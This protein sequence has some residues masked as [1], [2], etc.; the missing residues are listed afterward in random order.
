MAK[1]INSPEKPIAN[2]Y[3][4]KKYYKIVSIS[5]KNN[6]SIENKVKAPVV[7]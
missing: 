6:K 3:Y 4:S 5:L 1:T 7:K 2:L